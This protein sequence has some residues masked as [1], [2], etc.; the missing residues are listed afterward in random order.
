MKT[1]R[2][3]IVTIILLFL[4]II[5]SKIV[6]RQTIFYCEPPGVSES[7]CIVCPHYKENLDWI[8]SLPSTVS[9]H[10]YDCGVQSIP[11]SI[12]DLNNVTVHDKTGN[13]ATSDL[14]YAYYKFCSDYYDKLPEHILFLHGHDTGWHQKTSISEI[15]SKCKQIIQHDPVEYINVSDEVFQD[16]VTDGFMLSTVRKHW[17][18][19]KDLIHDE[20]DSPPVSIL[21]IN[22]G[23]CY[24]CRSRIRRKRK[25]FWTNLA[26][27]TSNVK[28][29][30]DM[31]FVLE[32]C[33]H[34]VF[35]ENW[36]RDYIKKNMISMKDKKM[37]ELE[38]RLYGL[39]T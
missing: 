10:L 25:E 7:W 28:V 21:D 2:I 9:I 4:F 14:F 29:R 12:Q 17:S 5:S 39:S 37:N 31:G 33:N 1:D 36:V 15:Y 11:Q 34:F 20:S 27:F 30:S 18:K 38:Y 3:L 6:L 13:L 16:W 26:E 35:G 19:Y 24:V 23:E 22:G 8:F 32:G